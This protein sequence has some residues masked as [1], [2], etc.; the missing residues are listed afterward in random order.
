MVIT[1]R[2]ARFY[3]WSRESEKIQPPIFVSFDE[4]YK[5]FR[6]KEWS[7]DLFSV[8]GREKLVETLQKVVESQIHLERTYG[9]D[10]EG[11]NGEFKK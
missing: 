8:K 1:G 3:D 9:C 6:N 2:T 4:A 11:G 10:T 7:T 5:R